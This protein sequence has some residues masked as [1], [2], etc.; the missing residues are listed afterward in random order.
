VSRW[1]ML[2]AL[3][4]G[5]GLTLA[6]GLSPPRA[7]AQTATKPNVVFVLTDDQHIYHLKH[8]PY[9]SSKPHGNW[10]EFANAFENT[11]L[12][13]PTRA[14]ILTGQYSHHHGIKGNS[15]KG[16]RDTSTIATWLKSAGYRTG[17]IGKY[18][19]GYPWPNRP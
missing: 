15:G 5:A 12:C 10:I 2:K 19:N 3:A 4:S 14:T 18:L 11:P 6:G 1:Q 8:M 9:L 16:F 17:L 7:R 13:C